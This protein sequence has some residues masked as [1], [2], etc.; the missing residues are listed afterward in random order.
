MNSPGC[1]I[2]IK[3]VTEITVTVKEKSGPQANKFTPRGTC[4]LFLLTYA[5]RMPPCSLKNLSSQPSRL[6][7]NVSSLPAASR[8]QRVEH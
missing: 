8:T 6:I 1:L 2:E 7:S 4:T 5:T 3:V